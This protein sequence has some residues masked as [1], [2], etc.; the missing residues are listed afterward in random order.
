[1]LQY[2]NTD[3]NE[4]AAKMPELAEAGYTS[5][6]LPPPTK[7][8]GGLSVGYD[9]WDRFDLGSKD[10]RGSV[11]T[12]YGTEAELQRMIEIAHRFGI[13][14][15]F[16]NIMNHNAFDIPGYDANTPIDIYPGMVPEDF[17]L[18][19]TED[20]SYR[21][22]DN[23]RNWGDAW[24]VMN[25]GL[26]DL[27]D[28]ATEPG[29]TNLNFGRTEGSTFPKIKFLRHPDH[30][31]YYC[32][33]PD[34]T[35]VGFGTSNGITKEMLQQN[36]EFYSERVED[37][38][39]RSARWLMDRTKA[40]GLRLDAV[41]HVRADFFGATFGA[42][43]DSNDYGYGG[44]VQRQFNL[45][46]G[47]SDPN[48]RDTLFDSEKARDD[49]LLFGEHLGE[50]PGYGEYV[51]A[52]MRLVDNPLRQQFNDRLGNPSSGLQGLDQPGAGGFAP[53]VGVMHAQSHDNDY[54]ARKELQHAMYFTRAGIGLL[55][56]DGNN[57]AETLGESGGA[58]PRHANTNFLG[59]YDDDR[60]P[61]L[62]Y[63][64][65][66]FARGYQ[67]PRWG[68]ADFLAYE[69][70]DKRENP[71]MSDADGVTMLLMLNDNYAN[72]QARPLGT[73]FPATAFGNNA[74]L[75][76]YSSYGGGFYKYASELS[77]VVVPP[78]G[79]FVFSWK[80]P[81]PSDLWANGGG[82][83]I[84]ILQNGEQVGTM[85][86]ERKDGRDGDKAFNPY[87]LPDA[88]P[89]DLKYTFT[90][91]RVTNGTNL[92]FISRTDA[93][94]E[95][96]LMKLDGGI[97]LNGTRPDGS[98]DPGFRDHPPALATDVFMGYEQ[99]TFVDRQAPEKF[100]AVDVARCTFGSAG[101]ET[102]VGGG[103]TVNG[104]GTNPQDANAATFV[105]HDPDAGFDD[106][107]GTHP[108]TQFTDN[109]STIEIWA[110]TNS[111]GGGYRMFVYYTNDASN[112]EGAGG[113][114]IGTTLVA[115]MNYQ[116][117]NASD[118][119]NWWGRASI[120][121]P[122]GTIRYKIGIFRTFQPSMFPAGAFE[123]ARK[124]QGMTTF[125]VENFNATTKQ[126]FPHNDYAK[127]AQGN[128]VT[129]TG[130]AEGFHVIRA[131]AFLQRPGQASIY[132]TFLQT[133]YYDA[134]RPGGEIKFPATDGDTI[135]GQSYGAV[136]RTDTSV[137]E[138][139]YH[140]DDNDPSNDDVTTKVA[141]GNG[142]G[143]EP[144]L[145]ANKNN[146]YDAGETFT[147]LNGNGQWDTNVTAWT[148][149]TEITP[150]ALIN[151]SFPR[152]WRFDYRNIAASGP[153][154]I[155]VRLRELS[156]SEQLFSGTNT[157]IADAA[158]HFT[159]LTR[160]VNAAGDPQRMFVAFPTT[161]GE[162]VGEGYVMKIRFSDSLGDVDDETLKSR[163]VVKIASSESGSL[164]NATT[165]GT[166]SFQIIRNSEAGYHDLAF[167]M[168]NLYNGIPDFI[169]TVQATLTR[170]GN[171]PLVA[172]RQ[173][174][175]QQTAQAAFVNIVNPPEF[176][177]DGKR[178]EIV[179]P[180]VPNPTPEERQRPIVVETSTD[181]QS[182]SISFANDAG[183]A[184][185]L[186]QTETPLRTPVAVTSGSTVVTG[187]EKQ[188]AGTLSTTEGSSNVTGVGPDFTTELAGG[189]NIRIGSELFVVHTIVSAT[190]LATAET[191]A[192]SNSAADGFLQ[193]QFDQSVTI[194]SVLQIGG[195]TYTVG[196][197][198]SPS[199]LTLNSAYAG[200]TS[201]STSAALI[202]ANPKA[203][204]NR[205]VWTFLW[206]NMT[207]GSFTFTATA[208]PASGDPV[209]ATR[210][211][212]VVFRQIVNSTDADA[213][214]DN[215]GIGDIDETTTKPLPTTNPE[216]WQNSDIHVYYAYGHTNPISPDS[217]GDGLPDGLE[218][219]WRTAVD[220]PTDPA[221]DSNG[222]GYPNFIGDLDPPFYNTLDNHGSV[223]DVNSQSEGGDRAKQVAGSVTD[224]NNSD[225]DR[226][227]IPDGIEDANRN[228][229]VDGDG[230]ALPTDF[231]P[232]SGRNWP[233]NRMDPGE[234]WLETN[235]NNADTDDDGLSDG[236]GED[237][238]FDGQI[239]GD[240]NSNRTYDGGEQW[241]ET[242]P[243]NR[244]T[245]GDG[246]PDGW[247]VQN[248]L[249]PLDNGSLNM[250]TSTAGNPNNG[251][252]GDIDGDG[253]T[254]ATELVN[255]SD[256]RTADTG[257]PP[258]P[259]S[260]VIGPQQSTV[261]GAVTNAKEFT[262]WTAA[263]VIALDEYDGGGTNNQGG[264][265]YRGWDGFDS[266]RDLVAFYA[267][268]GGDV[269]QGGDGNFYF[270]VDLQDLRAFAEEGNLDI[271]V[272]VDTG[273]PAEGESALP[274]DIDTRTEM[275]WEAVI[276]A[277]SSNKGAV[278]V[279]LNSANNST[280]I[281]QDL[282]PFGVERRTEMSANGFKRSYYNA[283]LDAVEFSISRQALRDAGWNGLNGAQLNFQVFTT[284]DGTNN[285][286]TPGAGDIGGRSDIR[287]TIFDDWIASDYYKDQSSIGGSKSILYSWF[288]K[289]G[290]NDSGKR[291]KVMSIIHGN[292]AI[293]PG[294][295]T[296]ALINNGAS[297]GYY[298]PLDVH[299]AF[300]A[301]VAMHITP[302]LASSIEWAK[303]AS[304]GFR[305]GPALNARL[306]SLMT[307]NPQVVDLLGST[308]A[309]HIPAYFTN[310]FNAENVA[311]ASNFL[312]NIYGVV[313]STE[314]FWAP[315]RVLDL[316]TFAKIGGLGFDFTFADQM[317]H[318]FKWFGR[319]SALGDDGYRINRIN[320]VNTFVVNDQASTYRFQNADNGLPTPLR[321]LL[322]RKARGAQDQVVTLYS[323]W[324]DFA[325]K[326]QADA[327]DKNLRWIAS[328]PWIQIV[329][330]DQIA[331][332]QVDISVPADGIGDAWPVKERGSEPA[333]AT[334]V[335]PDYID[336]ATEENYD[337][338]YFGLANRE[339]GLRN[340][341]FSIRTGVEMP[342]V[343]GILDAAE[344]A[345]VI[346]DTWAHVDE[347]N[348][349]A[350]SLS[351]LNKLAHAT[352][353]A[354]LFVTAF[355]E[356][357]N[358]D[359]SKFSTGAYIS[360]D[361]DSKGLA[362]FAAIS[363]A[364]TRNASIYKRVNDWAQTANTT[365]NYVGQAFA[366]Q[367]DV[368]LDG[369]NEYLLY[370]DRFFAVFERLGGRM[371]ASWLRDI[372]SGYVTQVSG[373]F[374]SYAN[375]LTEEEGVSNSDA[376]RT[377]GFKDWF[378]KIDNTSA[379]GV[380]Y[381][382][383]YY[384]ADPATGG[385]GWKFTSSDGKIAKN[386]TL[387]AGKAQLSASYTVADYVKLYVRFGLSPDL[388][389]LM[390]NGQA[391]LAPVF[392]S[393]SEV[394]LMNQN[395]TGTV[396]SYLRFAGAGL[397]GATFNPAAG[398][399]DA[400]VTLDTV[401]MR[402]QAH[403]QQIE[404]EGTSMTFALGFETGAA[405]TLDSDSDGLPDWW[406]TQF[407][408][409]ANDANGAN[410]PTADNDG[411]GRTNLQEYIVGLNPSIADSASFGLTITRTSPS[412]VRLQFGTLRDRVYRIYYR[413]SLSSGTW[414]QTGG[415]ISGTGSIVE[416]IDDGS[417]TGT[418]PTNAQPRFYKLEVSLP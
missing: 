76:N 201:A 272:V 210:N 316:G 288:G 319:T 400:G 395:A 53:E 54:A 69:R 91:P 205:K 64:H 106:W 133:F 206:T 387:G 83:P 313:P 27:I 101:A 190:S 110:K 315:E 277:Y 108:A 148:K 185:L 187:L 332:A 403:T 51:D 82:Q 323:A 16:D 215:D 297:A 327:Y 13:R 115:E 217:D 139:W 269:A 191:A 68:D 45:S 354:S 235:P 204:G 216:T 337:H 107:T 325:T 79:Y 287:D 127:D 155:K 63:I 321:E 192:T 331:N 220:P 278:Y 360:P 87:N 223:P 394:N 372:D 100:A 124:K 368:D 151:S 228:G 351:G 86:Y 330:P 383:N 162:T 94:T 208:V 60:I 134:A 401:Q 343:F 180:D 263:D 348:D 167:T 249:D 195:A 177:S 103:A 344:P 243:L 202:D 326:A 259:G 305:D 137:S 175:A 90:V 211:A 405:L 5:L 333:V 356:Q 21:K 367:A 171:S 242:D 284:R 29:E 161:E 340:K 328:R 262:D 335:A 26:A 97:D 1:M 48:H 280:S 254:N 15:Y 358:N 341:V 122:P 32:F 152:E 298:R 265:L 200:A 218:V 417:G 310:D 411:D 396:R 221:A 377:S 238:D 57:Q 104:F 286:P 80:N 8:S 95:N 407:G 380:S 194:G 150:T 219:G 256:P 416:Y 4:L 388:L 364:Q 99:A 81:D 289:S 114:G 170:P 10:Q 268:D 179:L 374:A 261:I 224:P 350:T 47:F 386:I 239:A 11:R 366:E 74:Y 156:S 365:S 240:T 18:R 415:D 117:P 121:R 109:G 37:F 138:V 188:I 229:W 166:S 73:S 227:G 353:G 123:A 241:T 128:F 70:I 418:A 307:G 30:P 147:D 214:D 50:P 375:S 14:V 119:N 402:N 22:W 250:R 273:N 163:F 164:A 339:E 234:T 309:D 225:T 311:V 198:N 357:T 391:N 36:R 414:T 169:H 271:Y 58:F 33:T 154:T 270:R 168:P 246:L 253:F 182:V 153:A 66:Q 98:T 41:K 293:Q 88:D 173:V 247:E 56:T 159:T 59:Q 248:G 399:R 132:N 237:V 349:V 413:N 2:F 317:R 389:D 320:G 23:T 96:L 369:E 342:D 184:T 84:T 345:G 42:D 136:V 347:I 334:K 40:D 302:T 116:A 20:G 189:D 9:L 299:E 301:P 44:Q 361:T 252:S 146:T 363:Q 294:H 318:I 304:D 267:H 213:D 105:Y 172:T 24:Q 130:L 292:Q 75:Y 300:G 92:S 165:Q 43:K 118:G 373:S 282:T 257:V 346:A 35:Y 231:N 384:S 376:Y 312:S 102:Y 65:G 393:S 409:N 178:H 160:T 264:D 379:A 397:S 131:R 61:N 378:A 72:G 140:I 67:Q 232:W 183:T 274:D 207:A 126:F 281:G 404:V 6:W 129:Q 266:S 260:I 290:A 209:S 144:W 55:Y 381:V 258:P 352:L 336:H 322:G 157:D 125:K 308:F 52:G 295:V 203:S 408:L 186:A 34:G 359:L 291:A 296:Q 111:V 230:A 93:S 197:I 143:F 78:G 412:T 355:H 392:A 303:S 19:V 406:E 158:G 113:V 7:G 196:Q 85:S 314:V 142:I 193:P 62:L 306:A 12:R 145:D 244:D 181:V 279:D 46:R 385:T 112:P 199:Q 255:G 174:R 25:L 49:A 338:W 275:K 382:N 3:W 283:D 39:N 38:L 233:N 135:T 28:I 362:G 89:T 236:Y 410:G 371:T 176:D 31:E 390:Q 276:A 398:D 324:E 77:T 245:D 222:D 149:V 329:T 212:T 370:N 141:N 226:D 120:A 17:H 71:S 251:A 285:T